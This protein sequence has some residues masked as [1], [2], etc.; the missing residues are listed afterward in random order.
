MTNESIS[1]DNLNLIKDYFRNNG[2]ECDKLVDIMADCVEVEY[3]VWH[4]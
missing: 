2:Q 3:E 4:Y 1:V